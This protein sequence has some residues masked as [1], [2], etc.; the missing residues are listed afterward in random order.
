M[1]NTETYLAAHLAREATEEYMAR[2]LGAPFMGTYSSSPPEEVDVSKRFGLIKKSLKQIEA[3]PFNGKVRKR[4][5]GKI[6]RLQNAGATKQ[7]LIL[8]VELTTRDSL[9]RL[10]EWEYK[11]LRKADID[12]FESENKMTATRDGLKL[13]ID[14]LED[15]VGNP[16]V[17]E[18]KD[19]I[20]PD[21]VLD[22]LEEAKERQLFDSFVVLWAEK[23]PDPLLL[24]CVDGCEDYFFITEWGDDITFKQITQGKL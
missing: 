11:I 5:E 16:Q 8:K 15:Y 12:R 18:A 23:V 9:V 17:G 1:F 22:K 20:I 10:K 19:R 7:A 6:N 2:V 4:V 24:G 14:L 21:D 3:E 13:Y